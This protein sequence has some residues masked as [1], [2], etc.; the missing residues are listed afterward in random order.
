MAIES[1][2][3]GTQ[4]S[5]RATHIL[6]IK[7]VLPGLIIDLAKPAIFGSFF[8]DFLTIV[9]RTPQEKVIPRKISLD[10]IF[11]KNVKIGLESRVLR[12][13]GL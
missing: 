1:G 3:A 6:P 8:N 11:P 12:V 2:E 7:R 13:K 5:L 4:R 10:E 9:R